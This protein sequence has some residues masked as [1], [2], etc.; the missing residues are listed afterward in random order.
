MQAKTSSILVVAAIV[1]LVV[2]IA[3]G[4]FVRAGEVSALQQDVAKAI[5]SKGMIQAELDQTKADLEKA[6]ESK[7]MLEAEIQGKTVP[8][9][10]VPESGQMIHDAWIFIAPLE[11]GKFAVA[12]HVEGLEH[13]GP[14]DVY[15]VEGVTRTEPMQMIPIA[16]TAAASEFHADSNGNGLYW[17]VLDNDP[18][19]S[20]DKILLLYLPGMQMERAQ[21]LATAKL[22]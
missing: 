6:K 21:L 11:Q 19:E 5:E 16:P 1:A 2:G 8:I 14:E 10:F 4:Y 20:F 12:I 7:G 18:R 9:A 13:T 17:A 3:V 22:G 15:L